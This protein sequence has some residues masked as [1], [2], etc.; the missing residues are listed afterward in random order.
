VPNVG[1]TKKF[2][3]GFDA[4]SPSFVLSAKNSILLMA[5]PSL[6]VALATIVTVWFVNADGYNML[7]DGRTM[8][9]VGGV[10]A[11][12]VTVITFGLDESE[13]VGPKTVR[14]TGNDPA[15]V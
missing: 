4:V 3:P 5:P 2:V 1:W 7:V 14:V 13:P 11:A 10:F 12:F 8:L 15:F 6:A 9:T